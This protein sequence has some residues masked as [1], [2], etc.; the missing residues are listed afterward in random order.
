MIL[1]GWLPGL[2]AAGEVSE[3]ECLQ[4]RVELMPLASR[5]TTT[6][7]FLMGVEGRAVGVGA[8]LLSPVAKA[9]TPA[10][11]LLH[12]SGGLNGSHMQWASMFV[13]MGIATLIIDSF[14]A[15]GIVDTIADQSRLSPLAMIDDA[16]AGLARLAGDSRIDESK[17]AAVGY[18]RGATAAVYSAMRRFSGRRQPDLPGFAA[19][20]GFYTPCNT[21]YRS[22]NETTGAPILMLHGDADDYVPMRWAR[23]YAER[24]VASGA[25]ARLIVLPGA[26]HKF[27]DQSLPP[28]LFIEDGETTR[29]CYFVED[30]DGVLYG[31]PADAALTRDGTCSGRG[32]HVGYN[33]AAH[34]KSLSAVTDFLATAFMN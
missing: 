26:Q 13:R 4:A 33:A 1:R 30:A 16:L 14:T 22:D 19:H 12:D 6:A 10:V 17:I 29:D 3:M 25:D 15:R 24:L 28:L 21:H 11:V 31:G 8:L 2:G 20:I 32:A 27:D 23:A 7:E 9:R 5:T 34:G 18:S